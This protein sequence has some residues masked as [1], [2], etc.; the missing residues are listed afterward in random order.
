M[1]LS[2]KNKTPNVYTQEIEKLAMSLEGA[3]IENKYTLEQARS[4]STKQAVSAMKKNCVNKDVKTVMRSRVFNDIDE[5]ITAYI[6]TSND[7]AEESNTIMFYQNHSQ[8]GRILGRRGRYN[9]RNHNRGGQRHY[10]NHYNNNNTNFR[11]GSRRGGP[12][13]ANSNN[14]QVRV[15]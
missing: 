13:R 7:V 10:N 6:E 8:R 4:L 11:G 3:Y 5:A 12:N 15:T 1:T 9:G 2:L 14:N